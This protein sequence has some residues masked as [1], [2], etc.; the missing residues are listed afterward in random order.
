MSGTSEKCHPQGDGLLS[1]TGGI[2]YSIQNR[3]RCRGGPRTT[4]SPFCLPFSKGHTYVRDVYWILGARVSLYVLLRVLHAT[5]RALQRLSLGSPGSNCLFLFLI[6]ERHGRGVGR[7]PADTDGVTP[8]SIT[9]IVD[10]LNLSPEVSIPSTFEV[11]RWRGRTRVHVCVCV[12]LETEILVHLWVFLFPHFVS[13]VS[14]GVRRP[15]GSL[16]GP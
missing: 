8:V 9:S 10:T 3:V 2:L 4:N 13:M 12:K 5:F 7:G 6:R 14:Q 16:L 1:N 15:S 11:R